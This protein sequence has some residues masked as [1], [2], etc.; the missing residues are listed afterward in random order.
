M[1]E[2]GFCSTQGL[3][4]A[5]RP[6]SIPDLNFVLGVAL[7]GRAREVG[8]S[9]RNPCAYS[10][11]RHSESLVASKRNGYKRHP[12]LRVGDNVGLAPVLIGNPARD[13][14]N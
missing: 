6:L 12:S 14:A 3:V 7:S 13:R 5:T 2:L 8:H 4:P 1:A 10:Y 11:D 9:D